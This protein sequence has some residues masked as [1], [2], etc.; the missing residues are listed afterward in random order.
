MWR[1]C[2]SPTTASTIQRVIELTFS[3]E[4]IEV[5]AVGDGEQAIARIP[6]ERP[7]IV[8]ADIAMPKR[9]GY[10]VAA[11]VKGHPEFKHIPV[12]LLAGAFEPVDDAKAEQAGCDGVLVK[13]FEPQHVVARVRELLEGVR[14]SPTQA[15]AATVARPAARLTAE[16][17]SRVDDYF[18]RLDTAFAKRGGAA[19]STSIDDG[20]SRRD[21][22]TL[23]Q[24]LSSPPAV[25]P[26]DLPVNNPPVAL[27]P[28][29]LPIAAP[30]SSHP[31][32]RP[33]GAG[34]VGNA[35]RPEA[36][37][38]GSTHAASSSTQWLRFHGFR[39]RPR[40][41]SPHRDRGCVHGLAGAGTGR[42][43][44]EAGAPHHGGRGTGHLRRSGRRGG[45]ACA[46]SASRRRRRARSS[47]RS[48]PTIAERLVREEIAG[49]EVG[50]RP[51]AV[52]R[53]ARV[54]PAAGC[55]LQ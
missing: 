14:G 7:D 54:L 20:D 52:G 16:P 46:R 18:D 43:R 35:G 25:P 6:T 8:L 21:V 33:R 50:S 49:F 27:T 41:R 10:E 47:S 53:K 23:D 22:P 4:D 1:S 45:P 17:G 48:C 11:F 36:R 2:C 30:P 34:R 51:C 9:S 5:V 37:A 42:T 15:A 26:I 3:G 19:A 38:S 55:R 12:L 29:P 40:G 44:C 28:L 32:R 39:L 13:P 31:K 24:V